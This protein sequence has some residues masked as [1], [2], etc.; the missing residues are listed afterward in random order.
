[1]LMGAIFIGVMRS[2]ERGSVRDVTAIE[3]VRGR[4]RGE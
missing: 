1:M 2:V 4:S 3:A